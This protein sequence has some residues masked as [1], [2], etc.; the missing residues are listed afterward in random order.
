[1]LAYRAYL[2]QCRYLNCVYG[3][4]CD[5]YL[6]LKVLMG[7]IITKKK[8]ILISFGKQKRLN[9]YGC[10]STIYVYIR[11]FEV[12]LGILN[13]FSDMIKMLFSNINDIALNNPF[14]THEL[15]FKCVKIVI[16][17]YLFNPTHR[18]CGW[19]YS[20]SNYY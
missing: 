7:L 1:M 11:S 2:M 13:Y 17:S 10:A 9:P 5:V 4:V 14:L 20:V 16:Y 6:F 19:S 18:G 15:C 3:Y 12:R 8:K